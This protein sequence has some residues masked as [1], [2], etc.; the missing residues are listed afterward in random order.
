[1]AIG[2]G[3]LRGS[4]GEITYRQH[5]II[6]TVFADLSDVPLASHLP[7]ASPA[8]AAWPTRSERFVPAIVRT[9]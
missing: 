7:T 8:N 4:P 9:V 3:I 2:A 5:A 1:M 6:E